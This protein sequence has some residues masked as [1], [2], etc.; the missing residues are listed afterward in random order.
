M[1]AAMRTR[2]VFAVAR[3][4]LLLLAGCVG[5]AGSDAGTDGGFL[6]TPVTVVAP[7]H[8]VDESGDLGLL[9]TLR[10]D[11]W[12]TMPAEWVFLETLEV[13]AYD[14]ATGAVAWTDREVFPERQ[15]LVWPMGRPDP[16]TGVLEIQTEVHR[17]AGVRLDYDPRSQSWVEPM[18]VGTV[19]LPYTLDFGAFEVRRGECGGSG[20]STRIYG[21]DRVEPFCYEPGTIRP[22]IGPRTGVAGMNRGPAGTL[23][24]DALRYGPPE[25]RLREVSH[26]QPDGTL[27]TESI[28]EFVEHRIDGVRD[29]FLVEV[30]TGAVVGV[31]ERLLPEG[32]DPLTLGL[33]DEGRYATDRQGRIHFIRERAV[34]R[35]P[36]FRAAIDGSVDEVTLDW[37]DATECLL[38][39]LYDVGP[40]GHILTL[41]RAWRDYHPTGIVCLFA[42]DGSHVLSLPADPQRVWVGFSDPV[43]W[44]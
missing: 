43:Q 2:E 44:Y 25:Q 16:R 21:R 12:P 20:F 30:E 6:D 17:T 8:V 40:Q 39:D 31:G 1:R 35:A 24:L 10:V 28:H 18:D 29:V 4:S 32:V 14:D 9:L 7:T 3:S 37:G 34:T 23:M 27:R 13:T 38:T 26:V 19:T 41:Q 42:P 5:G 33:L 22:P 15:E 11:P 36:I